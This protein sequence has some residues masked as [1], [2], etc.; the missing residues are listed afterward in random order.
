[1]QLCYLLTGLKPSIL[2]AMAGF[3]RDQ[4]S[5][6]WHERF[7]V[8]CPAELIDLLLPWFKGFQAAISQAEK[9]HK[10]V[11][12]SAYGVQK[13]LPYLC[14]VVVQD[15]LELCSGNRLAAFKDN[16]VHQLLLT[17]STFQ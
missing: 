14:W 5:Q 12:P 8:P 9:D 10:P 16:P 7:S 6:Y 17:N 13:L 4:P 15:A 3:E 11:Y 1:M 2:L